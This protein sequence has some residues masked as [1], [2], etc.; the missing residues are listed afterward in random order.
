M[1]FISLNNLIAI[2]EQ[3]E[4]VST[5]KQVTSSAKA[6]A[7]AAAAYYATSRASALVHELGHATAGLMTGQVPTKINVRLKPNLPIVGERGSTEFGQDYFMGKRTLDVPTRH[8]WGHRV[9]ML[10]AGPL[11]GA[12]FNYL[13]LNKLA[14]SDDNKSSF[15][16][17]L[18]ENPLRTGAQASAASAL[19][20]NSVMLLPFFKGTD[21]NQLFTS[22]ITPLYRGR[23]TISLGLLESAY[24]TTSLLGVAGTAWWLKNH[25]SQQWNWEKDPKMQKL[26]ENPSLPAKFSEKSE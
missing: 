11:T 19:L 3:P 25:L 2:D 26:F 15:L 4:K 8:L 24:I 7:G 10:A 6:A 5:F 18:T 1:A 21:G 22:L 13:L 14:Q 20:G 17:Q 9:P 12:Y 23:N 16:T